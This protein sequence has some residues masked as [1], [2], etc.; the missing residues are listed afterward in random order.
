MKLAYLFNT[1]SSVYTVI[2]LRGGIRQRIDFEM[3][4]NSLKLQV[5]AEDSGYHLFMVMLT[6]QTLNWL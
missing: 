3:P 4:Y 6:A 2:V 5:S 1:F